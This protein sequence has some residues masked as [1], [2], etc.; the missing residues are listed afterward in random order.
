MDL[1][2]P[3]INRTIVEHGPTDALVYMSDLD[4]LLDVE[5]VRGS[6]PL[7]LRLTEA[8]TLSMAALPRHLPTL[9]RSVLFRAR[10]GWLEKHMSPTLQLRKLAKGKNCNPTTGWLGWHF[11]Y[12]M[13][14]ERILH[15]LSNFAHA[16]DP[17]ITRITKRP[18]PD[19]LA[20]MDRRVRNCLDVHGRRYGP[21]WAAYDGKMPTE[22]GWPRNPAAPARFNTSTLLRESKQYQTEVS[23]LRRHVPLRDHATA[24]D[25]SSTQPFNRSGFYLEAALSKLASVE[26]AIEAERNHGSP[27]TD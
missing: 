3:T 5:A 8:G 14:T 13:P 9:S 16:H 11:G 23:R 20:E 24:S 19:A 18:Y 17:F 27:T 1:L 6:G 4:E 21:A 15:K 25:S 22:L 10:S 12:F 7:R 2:Q 26:K